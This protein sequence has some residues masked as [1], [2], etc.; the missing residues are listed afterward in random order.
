MNNETTLLIID[1]DKNKQ[2]IEDNNII[3]EQH[4]NIVKDNSQ[5]IKNDNNDLPFDVKYLTNSSYYNK[6][7]KTKNPDKAKENEIKAFKENIKLY[8]KKIIKFTKEMLDG[9]INAPNMQI[10]E[11]FN[12]Y[13]KE[14][15]NH[16]EKHKTD[17]DKES[18]ASEADASEADIADKEGEDEQ[19]LTMSAIKID[20]EVN[21]V[22]PNELIMT[23]PLV[24]TMMDKNESLPIQETKEIKK[25]IPL[26]DLKFANLSNTKRRMK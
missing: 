3:E 18:D 15:I 7:V 24:Q 6:L 12:Y 4:S 8:N 26:Y 21:V 14:L 10:N 25:T 11:L 16:F 13:I 22:E 17:S 19:P 20:D 5:T 2:E 1:D 9:E 23:K